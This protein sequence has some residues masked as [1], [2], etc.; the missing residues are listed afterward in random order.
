MNDDC[1]FFCVFT[2]CVVIERY[3]CSGA[4]DVV[5]STVVQLSSDRTIKGAT[6]HVLKVNKTSI[7]DL[8]FY[9]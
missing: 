1:I 7:S 3:D 5:T 2:N 6:G 9:F 4:G 8:G